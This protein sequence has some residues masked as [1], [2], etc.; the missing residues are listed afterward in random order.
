MLPSMTEQV[1][2]SGAV[3]SLNIKHTELAI[4]V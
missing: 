4:N 1:A 2:K 3:Y